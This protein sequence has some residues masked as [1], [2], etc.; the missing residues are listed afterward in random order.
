MDIKVRPA[1]RILGSGLCLL[2][3]IA[4]FYLFRESG[5]EAVT[6]YPVLFISALPFIPIVLSSCIIGHVPRCLT[7][8]LSEETIIELNRA[9]RNF[10][11]FN[12][13]SIGFAITFI[14]IVFLSIYFT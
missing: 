1:F 6:Q 5:I 8:L 12:A 13:Q 11:Q 4:M 2:F 9:E 3:I 10:T 7:R 14:I